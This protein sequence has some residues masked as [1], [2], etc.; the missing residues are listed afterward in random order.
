LNADEILS[1]CDRSNESYTFTFQWSSDIVFVGRNGKVLAHEQ[2]VLKVRGRP[3]SQDREGKAKCKKH[4][5]YSNP[6]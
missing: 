6:F 5:A 1:K 2:A 4:P 3:F